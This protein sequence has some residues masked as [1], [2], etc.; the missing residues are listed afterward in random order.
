MEK[1]G[2]FAHAKKNLDENKKQNVAKASQEEPIVLTFRGA[3]Q[4]YQTF[5]GLPLS[6][7][8]GHAF[9]RLPICIY[10]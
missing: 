8:P 9:A 3:L 6:G 7:Q 4:S 10:N 2:Y 5:M 1:F